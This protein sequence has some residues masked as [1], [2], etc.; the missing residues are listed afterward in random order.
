MKKILIVGGVAAG[1][2]AA[3]R[4]RRLNEDAKIIMFEKGPHVSFANCGLPYHVGGVIEDREELLLMSPEEFKNRFNVEA[5][6]N[7]EVININ[8]KDK[9]VKVKDLVKDNDYTETYDELVLA[10]GASALKPPIPGVETDKLFTLRNVV[11]VDKINKFIEE[12]NPKKAVVVGGGFIGLE[13][14][15]NLDELDMDVTLVEMLDQVMTSVD[16]DIAEFLHQKIKNKDVNL[17]LNN[18]VDSFIEKND[19]TLV[20][21][22]NGDKIEA[23]L[24]IL[25]IGVKPNT[26]FL[27]DSE[28]ELSDRGYIKVNDKMLTSKENVYAAGDAVAIKN[29]ITNEIQPVP[30]AGMA[31][32]QARILSNNICG[33]QEKYEGSIATSIAKVFDLAVGSVGI[34]E[35]KLKNMGKVKDKDYRVVLLHGKNHVGYFPGAK[36][37]CIKMI[38]DISTKKILGAQVIGEESVDK[39]IDVFSTVIKFGGTYK[40]LKSLE[41]A[42]AP[43][44]GGAKDLINNAG[45]IADNIEKGLTR[46]IECKDLEKCIDNESTL[47]DVR[48]KEEVDECGLVNDATHIPLNELR[49][50]L[51]ELDKNKKI[52]IYCA[53]G[54]RGY[55]AVRILIQNNFD[56]Y[57]IAGG[58]RSITHTIGCDF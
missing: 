31:N 1:A 48:T 50:R 11:D 10:P 40:D 20:K 44:F 15:E 2:T 53:A 33:Y 8:T 30:L 57:N 39:K 47:L 46:H 24:I 26:Q 41:M 36:L 17:I 49:N 14:M 12:N 35:K 16:L 19:K 22:N 37:L 32:K 3:A 4:I 21:L 56:A 51:N 13:M 45:Y 42:Y 23:D 55:I 18:G 9:S 29:Y 6:V 38:Y 43:S 54:L 52:Y 5:R 7:N 58:F 28:V 34:N 25:S 27:N